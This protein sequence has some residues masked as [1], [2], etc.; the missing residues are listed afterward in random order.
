MATRSQR[1]SG[2]SQ[3]EPPAG[4]TVE[5]LCEDHAGTYLIPYGCRFVDG[6][7]LGE[8]G[9]PITAKVVGWRAMRG[10]ADTD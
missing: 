5:L 2:F 1:I 9:T 3:G 8:R 10:S 7:W 4:E 6:H